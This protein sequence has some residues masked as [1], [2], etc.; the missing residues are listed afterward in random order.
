MLVKLLYEPLF[1]LLIIGNFKKV[2]YLHDVVNNNLIM[3]IVR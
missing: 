3:S 2:K 1:S